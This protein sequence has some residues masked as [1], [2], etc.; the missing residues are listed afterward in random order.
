MSSPTPR[1]LAM[2]LLI[3][4]ACKGCKSDTNLIVQDQPD[5]TVPETWTNDWGAW[6][7]M[8]V[9]P[10]GAPAVGYYDKTKGAM[11]F[12]LGAIQEDG[13]VT[14]TH[15]EVDGY[16]EGGMDTGDRG[17]Y[18]SMAVASDGTV[19]MAGYDV[20]NGALRYARRDTAGVWTNNVADGGSGAAP[21]TGWFASIAL[22]ADE[23]P[24]IANYDVANKTLRIVHGDKTTLSFS[25]SVV[26][27]GDAV[28]PDTGE[29][30][31]ADVG[32]FAKLRI[33]DGVEYIAYYD[34]AAGDLKLARGTTGAYSV[35]VVDSDGDVGQ[36]P[37]VLVEDGKITIAYQDMGNLDLKVA[38]GKP[39][40]W[41][42][43]TVDEGEYAG[44]DSALF[45]DGTTL[46]VLYFDGQNNDMKLAQQT[47][48]GWTTET[49][50][51]DGLAL[52]FHNEVISTGGHTWAG[53][54]DYT[55]GT[56]WF[57]ALN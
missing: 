22:D 39:G 32:Q 41:S 3:F 35:E 40:S 33:V 34:A 7:S 15:E 14:W 4:P 56:L 52:G 19:W 44:A 30:L 27:E 36:W 43:E 29:P 10:D 21:D 17:K 48:G 57:E 5:T 18:A 8:G 9:M 38:S 25:P 45:R 26:D 28:T 31:E 2:A 23:N 12:A 46:S 47:G 51:G 54:Y 11:G 20:G 55:N 42:I 24:V 1:W 16:A 49:V 37:D 6:L 50:A 53:C 13:S